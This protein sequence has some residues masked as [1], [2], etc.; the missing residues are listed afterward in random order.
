MSVW[1]S[2]FDFLLIEVVKNEA[3]IATGHF[4]G[5]FAPFNLLHFPVESL[6]AI[7]SGTKSCAN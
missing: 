1:V 2:K 7:H 4:F 5:L 3:G 6:I